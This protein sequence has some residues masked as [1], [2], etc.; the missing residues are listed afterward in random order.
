VALEGSHNG[1]GHVGTV[2]L[3][4]ALLEEAATKI[5]TMAPPLTRAAFVI[6][7]EAM[8][9]QA[10]VRILAATLASVF[11]GGRPIRLVPVLPTWSEVR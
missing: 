6:L 8:V 10:S 4:S 5:S 2:R 3:F 9:H 7:G 11:F 1:S